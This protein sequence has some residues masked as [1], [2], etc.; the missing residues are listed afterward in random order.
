MVHSLSLSLS[1]SDNNYRAKFD[2]AVEVWKRHT[3]IEF[4]VAPNPETD[5]LVFIKSDDLG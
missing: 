3:C 5:H 1:L 2:K 4:E